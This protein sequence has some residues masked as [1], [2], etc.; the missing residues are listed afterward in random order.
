MRRPFFALAILAGANLL[1]SSC[2][3]TPPAVR[4]KNIP[5]GGCPL[6]H[7]VA[8]DDP[9]CAAVYACVDETWQLDR[10]CPKRADAS[11]AVDAAGDRVTSG[12]APVRDVSLPD[13]AYGG[14]GCRDLQLPECSL[15]AALA[16]ASCCGCEELFVCAAGGW[17]LWG[18]CENGV[19][20][21]R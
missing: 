21:P 11:G 7:G 13:G 1:A 3:D 19:I 14:P 18:T 2:S 8:C 20:T 9:A 10:V 15:G 5:A 4:C 12:D 17:N 6:S 16:C